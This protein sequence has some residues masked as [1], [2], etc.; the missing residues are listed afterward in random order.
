MLSCPLRLLPTARIT[1]VG[2]NSPTRHR[3]RRALLPTTTAVHSAATT[4]RWP[5]P[6]APR[7]PFGSAN[8][9]LA[10]LQFQSLSL[11][12]KN[13]FNDIMGGTQDNGTWA[14]D[15]RNSAGQSAKPNWFESIGGDGGQSGVDSANPNI[16]F[17]NYFDALPDINFEATAPLSWDFI[18]GPLF[19]SNDAR[20][21]YI[22]MIPDPRV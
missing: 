3:A 10:T 9:G 17:H 12:F 4:C 7:I 2:S 18:G 8:R 5:R 15:T 13:P 14:S 6:P 22:P 21:F 16:R 20:S 11:N 1:P 19:N